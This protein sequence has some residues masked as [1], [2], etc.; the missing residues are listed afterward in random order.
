[1][2][3]AK[4]PRRSGFGVISDSDHNHGFI[5]ELGLEDLAADP[6]TRLTQVLVR[7]GNC[8]FVSA[9]QDAC[10]IYSVLE[11]VDELAYLRDISIYEGGR[12]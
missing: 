11:A 6:A 2:E 5:S 10:Y 4:E 8:R 3:T 7:L 9:A 1:M 12:A